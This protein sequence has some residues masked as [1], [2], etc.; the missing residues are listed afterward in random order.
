MAKV[1]NGFV[2]NSSSSSFLVHSAELSSIEYIKE[3]VFDEMKKYFK[4]QI[5]YLQ[6]DIQELGNGINNWRS[7]LLNYYIEM[8]KDEN[9]DKNL[10][11]GTTEE[12][13][14][15][16]INWY[17]IH[18]INEAEYVIM[19]IYDNFIPDEVAKKI[20]DKFYIRDYN[21]HMG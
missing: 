11:F 18:D 13:M 12:Y 10:F 16:I 19:D 8:L 6:K 2:S 9:L 14:S 4:E 15:D 21:L 20:I 17:K 7:N 1:R 3:F 5:E